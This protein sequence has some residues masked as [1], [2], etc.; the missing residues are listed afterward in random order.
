MITGRGL[1]EKKK[2]SLKQSHHNLFEIVNLKKG[3]NCIHI[4]PLSFLS[5]KQPP[6]IIV[7]LGVGGLPEFGWRTPPSQKKDAPSKLVPLKGQ[8]DSFF[9]LFFIFSIFSDC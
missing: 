2:N 4:Q 6:L 1:V 5:A 3:N 7:I 9:L 8:E